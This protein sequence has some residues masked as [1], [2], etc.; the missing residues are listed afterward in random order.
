[1]YLDFLA[2]AVKR[3]LLLLLLLLRLPLSLLRPWT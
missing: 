2:S 3:L 1:M